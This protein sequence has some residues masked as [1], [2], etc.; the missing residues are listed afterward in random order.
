MASGSCAPSLASQPSAIS[1]AGSAQCTSSVTSTTGAWAAWRFPACPFERY[2][3]D[4]VVHCVSEDQA[5]GLHGA[6]AERM[7]EVGL[8]LHPDKTRL[9]YCR[10]GKRRGGGL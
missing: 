3:D 7:G 9:V 5:K 1:E 8:A 4:C 2:A 10:D 6:T